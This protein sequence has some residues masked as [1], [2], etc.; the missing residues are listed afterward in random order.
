MT[1]DDAIG[2]QY[3]A[4]QTQEVAV[5]GGTMDGRP[6]DGRG[7]L[8]QCEGCL[9]NADR[10]D[11][12]DV[13]GNHTPVAVAD[14]AVTSLDR[15]VDVH[16]LA[17]DRD[18]DGEL[19]SVVAVT[20]GSHGSVT[21]GHD[22]IVR[23]APHPDFAVKDTFTYTISD[24][25]SFATATVTVREEG[26]PVWISVPLRTATDKAA[27]HAGGEAGQTGRT[28]AISA[29][30]P[31]RLAIGIDTAGV[32]VSE[33]AG[34]TWKVRRDGIHSNGVLSIAFDPANP[35]V[36]WA[37]GFRAVPGTVRSVPPDPKYY[38]PVSDGIYRSPDLGRTWTRLKSAV[39]L[40]GL[41]QN[42]Y[43]AFDPTGASSK[44]SQRI[45]AITHDA[46]LLHTNDGGQSWQGVGPGGAVYNAIL[47][48]PITGD[49]W[50][51]GD[52]GLWWSGDS[53]KSW[54][55]IDVPGLPVRGI[56]VHPTDP[57]TVWVALG[58]NGVWRSANGGQTWEKRTN[59]LGNREWSRVVI[60]PA[61][62]SFLYVDANAAGVSPYY[63]HDGG[64]TWKPPTVREPG[65]LGGSHFWS[66]GMVAH[67]TD[68]LVAYDFS[69]PRRTTDG[70]KIWK[71]FGS[72]ISGSRRGYG[73]RSAIAY[74][75]DNPAKMMFFH[76]DHGATLTT[77]GGDTWT[78]VNAPRQA[79][80]GAMTQPG[81]AYDSTPGSRRVISAVGGWFK[82]R[83]CIS[84][85]DGAT[86]TVFS[87]MVDN[88][89]FFAWHT[90]DPSV[91]YIGTETGG[92]RSDDA[93][94]TWTV[95][96]RPVRA[97]YATNNNVIFAATPVSTTRTRV[98][99]S[100][101][102]GEHWTAV[103]DSL[104]CKVTDIDVHPKDPARIY[105]TCGG[106]NG[107]IQVYDGTTWSARKEANGLER[108]YSGR[109]VFESIAVDPSFPNVVYAGQRD[110]GSPGRG[111]ARKRSTG[112]FPTN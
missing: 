102:R 112:I 11:G 56:A 47:R 94:S 95:L 93:G 91:V 19:L 27:E 49:L 58:I 106:G 50:L 76:T 46:G 48:H 4:D 104:L 15:A 53:A 74:R 105:A 90:Q 110:W 25:Q 100:D 85:D 10:D 98:E 57:Q 66:Q 108:D 12:I 51:A 60:S 84:K 79:D 43:F 72:G 5:E 38:T 99:R 31:T 67:P 71:L 1:V 92:L 40:D 20:Q 21:I 42:E 24:G 30:D 97:V 65:F 101:D 55:T 111:I 89:R 68:P 62:P 64:L 103:G 3:A 34:A 2:D 29:Q 61:N 18:A 37:A 7:E 9:A 45:Y 59:G 83:L 82:Q 14:S 44:G 23:Y 77:D 81:G 78:H 52:E 109:M 87:D 75:R 35:N 6:P 26:A 96:E 8:T 17:N 107:Q 39:F 32:Y 63:S 80:L 69:P 33:D 28:M 13:G 73:G 70:G 88:Y 86:W 41:A 22:G 16:I 36:L 54:R